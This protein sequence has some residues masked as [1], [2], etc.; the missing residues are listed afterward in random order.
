MDIKNAIA[1]LH[2]FLTD[3]RWELFQTVLS[4]RTD[5]LSIVLEDIYDPH[6]ANAVIR[7]CDCFGVQDIHL[8][9]ERNKFAPSK[10]VTQGSMKWITTHRY[11]DFPE[12][13]RAE[14]VLQSLKSKG[15][16]VVA[17]TPHTDNTP[18][19]IPFHEPIALVMGN[20]K[21]GVSETV[22]EQAD[23]LVKIPM[24]GFTESFNISVAAAL[25]LQTF[26]AKLDTEFQGNAE[27]D[28]GRKD[29]L[30]LEW[31]EKT[32]KTADLILKNAGVLR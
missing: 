31:M 2:P 4:N 10:R 6:N 1:T 7:S 22:L 14:S 13:K 15:V 18:A 3:N 11:T 12:G 23:Y 29:I 20:E 19:D 28:E 16:K 5:K 9:E 32:I 30:M 21:T 27:L 24:L 17:T 8:I 25:L 26:R